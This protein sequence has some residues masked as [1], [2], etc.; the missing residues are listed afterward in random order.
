VEKLHHLGHHKRPDQLSGQYEG[1]MI[2]S[3]K[4]LHDMES[5]RRISVRDEEFHW[6]DRT[7]PYEI[8]TLFYSEILLSRII[9]ILK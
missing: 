4:Q 9:K 2:I 1:D 7:V 6:L 5:Y 8:E 3:K